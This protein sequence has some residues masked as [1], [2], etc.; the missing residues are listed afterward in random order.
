MIFRI[1]TRLNRDLGRAPE[2]AVKWAVK[3]PVFQDYL[4]GVLTGRLSIYAIRRKMLARTIRD[5]L[6][7]TVL[8]RS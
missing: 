8:R 3:D 4:I 2:E 6:F 5:V 7:Y 1:L